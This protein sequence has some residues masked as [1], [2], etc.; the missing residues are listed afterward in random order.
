MKRARLV[1]GGRQPFWLPL[2]F[3]VFWA[4]VA[5]A[6]SP[7][8]VDEAMLR[9]SR[10]SARPRLRKRRRLPAGWSRRSHPAVGECSSPCSKTG[11]TS[12]RRISK[13]F[14]VKSNDETL[15]TLALV[16][17][18]TLPMAVRRPVTP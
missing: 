4:A 17:P 1:M 2:A 3:V 13:V 9:T 5:A 14:I 12:A 10:R 16:D 8:G 7:N 18:V 15:N 6:Q 11:S